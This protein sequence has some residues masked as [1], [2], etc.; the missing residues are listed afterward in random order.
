MKLFA[1]VMNTSPRAEKL[2]GI[3]YPRENGGFDK[4]DMSVD[5]C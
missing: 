1:V 4:V 3:S 2:H 5:V